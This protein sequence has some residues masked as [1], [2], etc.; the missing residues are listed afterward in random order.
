MIRIG[1]KSG[2]ILGCWLPGVVS[3]VLSTSLSLL[4]FCS[5]WFGAH[6]ALSAAFILCLS[7]LCISIPFDITLPRG[8]L[9]YPWCCADLHFTHAFLYASYIHALYCTFLYTC[10]KSHLSFIA[11]PFVTGKLFAYIYT[12]PQRGTVLST[13]LHQLFNR[14]YHTCNL[15]EK[16]NVVVIQELD[17]PS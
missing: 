7:C 6:V 9:L 16:L 15:D 13:V 17:Y 10:Y 5:H 3:G 11:T 14:L 12:Y 1:G 2:N 4:W 8:L